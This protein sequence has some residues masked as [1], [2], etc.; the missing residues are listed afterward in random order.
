MKVN[1]SR[2]PVST[3]FQY[4]GEE[5]IVKER[6]DFP[7]VVCK[8]LTEPNDYEGLDVLFG[9]AAEQVE[10]PDDTKIDEPKITIF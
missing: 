9:G 2:L 6:E 1:V 4:K 3:K 5:F 10:V 7:F 8:C